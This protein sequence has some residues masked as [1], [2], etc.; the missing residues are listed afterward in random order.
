[1]GFHPKR[2][3]AATDF[4]ESAWPA[5]LTAADLA[6]EYGASLTLVHVIPLSAY[7]DFAAGLDGSATANLDYQASVRSAVRRNTEADLARLKALNIS[8]EFITRDGVPA[9]EISRV[10]QEG[11]FDLVVVGTH[12]RTGLKHV[13]LGSVAEAVVRHCSRPVLTVRPTPA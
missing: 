6:K 4:S 7:V 2:V 8:A 12:G 5:I 9:L 3:L 11:S 1:M 10:A 13:L